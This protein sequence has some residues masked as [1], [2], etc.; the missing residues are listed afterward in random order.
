MTTHVGH[1]GKK[2]LKTFF[3]NFLKHSYLFCFKGLFSV[4]FH[5][6]FSRNMINVCLKQFWIM[7]YI[8]DTEKPVKRN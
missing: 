2:V 4:K 7:K 6:T 1:N 3:K 8:D 5:Q